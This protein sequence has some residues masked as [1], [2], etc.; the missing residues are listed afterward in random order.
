MT[1]AT[2]RS[3]IARKGIILA[4]GTGKRLYPLTHATSKQLLPIYDKPMIYYPLSTLML[5]GVRDL[6]VIT[7][8]HDQPAFQ[9][10]LGDGCQWGISLSY[11]VQ[12]DPQ[13]VAQAY[14][15]GAGFVGTDPSV[16]ALGDNLFYGNG[17]AETLVAASSSTRGATLF[18]YHVRDA[19]PYGV[20]TFD[21][22]GNVESLEEKPRDPRSQHAVTGLYLFDGRASEFA[23]TLVPSARGELEITDLARRYLDLGELSVEI[24]CR[25]HAWLDTGTANA[26]LDAALFVRVIE[27]RQ[28]FKICCPEEIAW[29]LGYIDSAQLEKLAVPLRKSG[30][31]DYLLQLLG[32]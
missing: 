17:L 9:A 30:Y 6:L 7:T 3:G 5:A 18:A 20:V 13:G 28:G 15:I 8:P 32:S 12:P 21:D 22:H 10:L 19:R 27:E 14:R 31:G 2:P 23:E 26:L 4:G 29:R 25:G 16:L 11:A 1:T 24:L